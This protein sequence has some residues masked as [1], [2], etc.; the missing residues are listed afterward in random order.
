M[1]NMLHND[2]CMNYK[3]SRKRHV[4]EE[5]PPDQ[6]LS[7]VN[8]ALIHYQNR[9][10]QQEFIEIFQRSKE[11]ATRVDKLTASNSNVS[12]D[13]HKIF[14]PEHGN[15]PPKRI[16]IEGAPGIG[17]TVLTKEIA[18]QWANGE[19]LQEYKLLFLLYLRDPKLHEVKSVNELLCL[20]TT[21]SIRDLR[22][23]ITES[24]GVNVAFVFDGFDECP[25]IQKES[26]ITDI[27]K[28][29]N[30]G[31]FFLNSVV[32]I[33]S[34]PT[35]T[36]FLHGLVDRRIEI[37]GFPKEERQKYIS[38]SLKGSLDDI[39]KLNQYLAQH[40]IIEICV[41]FLFI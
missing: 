32:V 12:K 25:V 30:D 1:I 15:I 28:S 4:E 8:L 2:L 3:S 27:I 33:T 9:R 16:L 41:I 10:T 34:R 26:F 14:V 31:K 18:Y 29:E 37:L 19:I 13:I 40:S 5:W 36:L 20:F 17:K 6:P 22:K 7:I 21:K 23:F 35:A 38:Q 39:Q 24:Y 11:G